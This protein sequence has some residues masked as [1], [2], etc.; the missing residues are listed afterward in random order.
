MRA[1]S[2]SYAMTPA[3][4]S[5]G[6]AAPAHTIITTDLGQ[7]ANLPVEDGLAHVADRLLDAGFREDDVQTMAVDNTVRLATGKG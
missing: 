5:S 6:N 7:P 1:I 2:T 3:N 4:F